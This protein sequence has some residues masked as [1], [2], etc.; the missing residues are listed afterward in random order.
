MTG[1]VRE[2]TPTNMDLRGTLGLIRKN[3]MLSKVRD[4]CL[5][6]PAKTSS[7]I[8]T[9]SQESAVEKKKKEKKISR[10]VSCNRRRISKQMHKQMNLQ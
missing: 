5:L 4:L 7:D 8:G 2:S 10:I 9:L 6:V 1:K 3:K